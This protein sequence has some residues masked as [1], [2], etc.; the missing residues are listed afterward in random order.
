M[1]ILS[2]I[3]LANCLTASGCNTHIDTMPVYNVFRTSHQVL[4]L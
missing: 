3:H 1:L 2:A 4:A